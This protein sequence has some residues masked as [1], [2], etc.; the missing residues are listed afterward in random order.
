MIGRD[1]TSGAFVAL[2]ADSRGVCR[3]YQMSFAGNV[4][5]IWRDAYGFHQRFTG[6]IGRDRRSIE[7]RWEKSD[8]GTTWETDFDLQYTKAE[9][10]C[11]VSGGREHLLVT[12]QVMTTNRVAERPLSGS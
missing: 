1:E 2:Y 9:Q 6:R 7:A 3:I 12:T 4:W 5:K 10:P 11:T 8:D